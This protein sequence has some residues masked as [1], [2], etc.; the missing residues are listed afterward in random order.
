MR[1]RPYFFAAL[2]LAA[3]AFIAAAPGAQKKLT[4]AIKAKA[5]PEGWSTP[6]DLGPNLQFWSYDARV[7][8]DPTGTKVAVAWVE[9]GGGGKRVCFNTN[10]TGSWESARTV[11]AYYM[12]GEY[13][14][15]EIAFDLK[16]DIVLTH[17]ARMGS[18][19]YEILYRKRSKGEWGEHENVSRT[20]TGGSQSSSFIISSANDYLLPY[21]DDW[22]RPYEDAT[23]WG[24]Y[25][26]LKPRGVDP[27]TGGGRVPDLSGR[28]YFPDA[29]SNSKG[30]GYVVWD[31]RADFGIS[32]VFF[33]ENK[34]PENK[35][36]RKSVV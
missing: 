2:L 23:Y 3:I 36:D 4:P 16:G 14:A 20:A 25:L 12:I 6:I 18:G 28:S 29:R 13:P 21:Q 27:W 9:E 34:T 5:L 10:E 33:S 19:N 8:T 7:A 30:Y 26:E 24:I 15:P 22:E 11:N 35:E 31:N 17:Q 1:S 32:H